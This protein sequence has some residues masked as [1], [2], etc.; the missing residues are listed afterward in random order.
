MLFTELFSVIL[1][2]SF[3]APA[4]SVFAGKQEYFI[5]VPGEPNEVIVKTGCTIQ[6]KLLKLLTP[7]WKWRY[8]PAAIL[9]LIPLRV[10][11]S[12]LKETICQWQ[13]MKMEL[14]YILCNYLVLYSKKTNLCKSVFSRKK[15]LTFKRIMVVMWQ[16]RIVSISWY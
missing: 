15:P 10:T 12:G 5:S 8:K 3:I 14:I 1:V 7:G 9:L 13:P 11:S 4:L 6:Y 16:S 2:S